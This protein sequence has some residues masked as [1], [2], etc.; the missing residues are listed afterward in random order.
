MGNLC[1]TLPSSLIEEK[2]LPACRTVLMVS[3][4]S[5]KSSGHC[6]VLY[7][8]KRTSRPSSAGICLGQVFVG[9]SVTVPAG[10][11]ATNTEAVLSGFEDLR[12]RI[13][14][15]HECIESAAATSVRF[16]VVPRCF[17]KFS[18]L[19]STLRELRTL[20]TPVSS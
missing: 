17:L 5:A 18:L 15:T 20:K 4:H 11:A 7:R 1:C 14:S 19:T 9:R 3:G 12:K 13:L 10:L 16:T 2:Y 6:N 8:S